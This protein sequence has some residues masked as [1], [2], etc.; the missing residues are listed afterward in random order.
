MHD[1]RFFAVSLSLCVCLLASPAPAQPRDDAAV[2]HVCGAGWCPVSATSGSATPRHESSLG[3]VDGEL[4]LIGGRGRKPSEMFDVETGAWRRGSAAPFQVHHF[5]AVTFDGE[6]WAVGAFTG[7]F[8]GERGVD[9]VMIYDPAADR[10]RDG[11]S[12]PP[13]RVRG[14]AGAVL[15]D[16]MIYVYGGATDGHRGGHTAW[17]DRLDPTTGAWTALPD[18][19]RT[20]DHVSIAAVDGKIVVA[21]G[22]NSRHGQPGHTTFS[23]TV[24]E[25]DVYNIASGTWT[26][27]DAAPI[28]TPRAGAMAAAH[29]GKVYVVGGESGAIAEAHPQ[30][31]VFDMSE[32]SWSAGPRLQEDRHGAGAVVL[33]GKLWVVGGSGR[34]GGRPEL[35]DIEHLSLGP[36]E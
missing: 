8:P 5:Q 35:V 10:W 18:G 26:T 29:A 34:R 22:R 24:E 23:D 7:G 2:T 19:P 6:V 20:R 21:G 32:R 11:P 12:I 4:V 25:T 36:A 28:P 9:R 17:L 1:P 31:E 3:V 16:G 14:A 15:V 13:D 30:T 27:I 33:D